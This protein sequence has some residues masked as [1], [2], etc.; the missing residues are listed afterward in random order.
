[1]LR[2]VKPKPAETPAETPPPAEK[3][4]ETPAAEKPPEKAPEKPS[5]KPTHSGGSS[6]AE[7][8]ADALAA[9]SRR[10]TAIESRLGLVKGS[11][12]AAVFTWLV[13][14]FLGAALVAGTVW[15]VRWF[16]RRRGQT[17]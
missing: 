5:E 8:P 11:K 2:D 7:L 15:A 13:A 3:P 16:I 9:V 10:V 1:M 6:V 12:A 14:T 17:T 4:A